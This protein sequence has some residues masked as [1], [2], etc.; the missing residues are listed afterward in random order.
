MDDFDTELKNGF[1]EEAAQLIS[2]AEQCFLQLEGDPNASGVLE[3]IFRIAH[4]LKGSSK[5]VGF[6]ELGAFTHEFENLLIKLK[7]K[8]LTVTEQTVSLLLRCNDHVVK[9]L[10]ALKADHAAQVESEVLLTEIRATIENGGATAPTVDSTPPPETDTRFVESAPSDVSAEVSA[11]SNQ[12]FVQSDDVLELLAAHAKESDSTPPII[13]VVEA[14]AALAD[15]T[16]Q[17]IETIVAPQPAVS[18]S[19]EVSVAPKMEQPKTDKKV[20]SAPA[21]GSTDE[22]IRVSLSRVETLLNYIGE[23]VILQTVLREQSLLENV[24]ELRKTIGQMGKVGK[25]LQDISMSLRMVPLKP[26]FQKMQ[27]IVRDTASSL[28]KKINFQMVG[29]DTEV[30]KTIL[31]SLSDPLVHLIRNACDHGIETGETRVAAGKAPEGKL[32][33]RAFNQSGSLIIEIQDDGAGLDPVRL[34]NKAVEKGIL[35]EGQAL[36]D[37]DAYNLIFASGFST[38]TQVTD[39]SGRGVGMDVVRTN[40]EKMQGDISIETVLGK[41]TTFRIKLPL[42]LAITGAMI[43]ECEKSRFV[44]PMVNVHE[45][46][47]PTLTDVHHTQIGEVFSLR[48]ETMPLFRLSRLLSFNKSPIKPVNQCIAIVVRTSIKP[49]AVLVDDIIGQNQVVIK[50]LGAEHTNLKGFGGSA[51]LGDGK[52]ALILELGDLVDRAMKSGTYRV[53]KTEPRQ[54]KSA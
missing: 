33:L 48:G 50:K 24:Q 28:S 22:S 15:T 2:D 21:G 26:T 4:N 47:Q 36:S 53:E 9:F 46:I 44:V 13:D 16:R 20:S 19:A 38:K 42:S 17:S 3:K 52:P 49:F 23:M 39:V 5:A 29:E 34:K 41:G 54:E 37:K 27:R 25:E 11:E 6:A 18:A 35:K 31:E 1:L 40:I 14:A 45:T 30:D 43:V 7:N 8:D 51:I 12:N 32:S 10:D